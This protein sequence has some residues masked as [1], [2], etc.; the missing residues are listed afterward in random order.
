MRTINTY[1]NRSN[2]SRMIEGARYSLKEIS[3]ICEVSCGCLHN[4][5]GFKSEFNDNDI[6][7]VNTTSVWPILETKSE[8]MSASWLKRR[9]I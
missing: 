5:F 3:I 8:I 2:H 7:K 4:R 6:R 1:V 9:L